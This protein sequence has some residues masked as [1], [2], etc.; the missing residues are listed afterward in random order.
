M[1][2]A[3]EFDRD[4]TLALLMEEIW[5]HGYKACSVKSM[6]EKTGITRSSF[7]KAFGSKEK[8]FAE[9]L[10]IY[11]QSNPG[12]NFFGINQSRSVLNSITE[13]MFEICRY[14][15]HDMACRGCPAASSIQNIV[16]KMGR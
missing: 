9:V 15:E 6:S 5:E 7:Y 16:K 12:K 2:R 10:D 13:N 14:Q 11:R 3:K 4:T 8:L 1:S